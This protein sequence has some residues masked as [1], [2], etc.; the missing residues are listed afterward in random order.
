MNKI[1]A[2]LAG[3]VVGGVIGYLI[4]DYVV[5]QLEAKRFARG[6]PEDLEPLEQQIGGMDQELYEFE[7][8]DKNDKT[9]YAG[10]T[11]VLL[12][13]K[14]KLEDIVR[15]QGY[16]DEREPYIMSAEEWSETVNA[17]ERMTILY[18]EMD[19]VFC[20]DQE[21]IIDDPANMF[22]PNVF[23]HFGEDSGDADVVYISN[24][25]RSEM[26][27]I[28]RMKASYQVDVLGETPPEV[29]EK[30]GRTRKKRES[31]SGSKTEKEAEDLG[32][33]DDDSEL[34]E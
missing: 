10:L 20:D 6:F 14:P 18:Y 11:K 17:Y 23:L 1:A 2:T 25:S 3:G 19:G 21:N 4:A 16:H 8:E 27:E 29:P 33:T 5:Y 15:E 28:L 31:P 7:E 26:Y 24:P 22:V 32:G 34:S 12:A 9:N 13:D 30:K